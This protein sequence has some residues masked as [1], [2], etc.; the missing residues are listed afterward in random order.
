MEATI[1]H[2]TVHMFTSDN[3]STF[4]GEAKA[5]NQYKHII[6]MFQVRNLTRM[7][8]PNFFK[9]LLPRLAKK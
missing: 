9:I 1:I 7:N 2:M 8:V 5:R 6:E 3:V 4:E